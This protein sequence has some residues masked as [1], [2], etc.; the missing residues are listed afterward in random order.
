MCSS[1]T[2]LP[3][4]LLPVLFVP[5]AEHG[6]A[7][8]GGKRETD[9]LCMA[10]SRHTALHTRPA[11][12]P[13]KA[14]LIRAGITLGMKWQKHNESWYL[15]YRSELY[16][17]RNAWFGSYFPPLSPMNC[18]RGPGGICIYCLQKKTATADQGGVLIHPRESA[19][20]SSIFP[21]AI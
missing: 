18:C 7:G 6:Q 9:P 5:A 2:Q 16:P 17:C 8:N 20:L 3:L 13:V 19:H 12:M 15:R 11:K 4:Q 21:K 1:A 10:D 14:Q